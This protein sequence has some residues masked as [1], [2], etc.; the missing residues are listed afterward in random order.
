[1][2]LFGACSGSEGDQE[3]FLCEQCF[4]FWLFS[5]SRFLQV[6][7]NG[8]RE[9]QRKERSSKI[10]VVPKTYDCSIAPSS[11]D[12]SSKMSFRFRERVLTDSSQ[13]IWLFRES[14]WGVFRKQ[15]LQI[16]FSLLFNEFFKLH[17]LHVHRRCQKD[18]L[19]IGEPP[20]PLVNSLGSAS[21][22]FPGISQKHQ[23]LAASM[24]HQDFAELLPV[25]MQ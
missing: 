18:S 5:P 14:L 12:V 20:G 7:K 10:F 13:Q 19:S 3:K 6:E 9:R 17:K 22:I 4:T 2:H 8:R 16:F 11:S 25:Q 15:L 24:K 21:L 23:L 1:M